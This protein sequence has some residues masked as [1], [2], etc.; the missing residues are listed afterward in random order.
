[1]VQVYHG[2]SQPW[3]NHEDIMVH[4][5]LASG[6]DPAVASDSSNRPCVDGLPFAACVTAMCPPPILKPY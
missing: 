1:M 2:N 4:K 3:D 6:V 5:R